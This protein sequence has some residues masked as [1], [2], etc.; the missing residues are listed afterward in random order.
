MPLAEP[1]Q[2]GVD[3]I[4]VHGRTVL[5]CKEKILIPVVVSQAF[6]L[7]LLALLILSEQ[8]HRLGAAAQ[9]CVWTSLILGVSSYR[10]TPGTYRTLLSMRM[11]PCSKSTRSHFRPINSPRRH[12]LIIRMVIMVRH[13]MSSSSRASWILISSSGWK[14]FTSLCCI[15]GSVAL[16][17]TF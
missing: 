6:D 14:W 13:L 2:P 7:H 16:F 10:P 15:F 5:L 1:V 17:A 12:P 4:R 11:V 9:W 3:R 8:F